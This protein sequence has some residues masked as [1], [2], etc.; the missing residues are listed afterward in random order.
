M[1]FLILA[2]RSLTGLDQPGGKLYPLPRS[3]IHSPIT[4]V[5]PERLTPLPLTEVDRVADR[6]Q[7]YWYDNENDTRNNMKHQICAQVKGDICMHH[8]Y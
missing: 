2:P 6:W 4:S 3:Y 5:H 7:A 1:P 8:A